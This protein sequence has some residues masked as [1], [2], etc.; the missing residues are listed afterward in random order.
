VEEDDESTRLEDIDEEEEDTIV[1]EL[2]EVGEDQPAG[3][4]DG[5]FDEFITAPVADTLVGLEDEHNKTVEAK[6]ESKT[7]F[8]YGLRMQPDQV[9]KWLVRLD[10]HQGTMTPEKRGI[11]VS[12]MEYALDNGGSK[13]NEAK[14]RRQVMHWLTGYQSMKD[15]PDVWCLALW[16]WL[17]PKKVGNFWIPVIDA[18]RECKA[19]LNAA[20][21][22]Q[23]A[24]L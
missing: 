7:D 10:A 23:E 16:N 11:I 20:Q 17:E 2:E 22:K 12:V 15:M 4:G 24:M 14:N 9:K 5:D 8:T 3:P 18:E 6:Q 19:I 13:N 1:T 21:P